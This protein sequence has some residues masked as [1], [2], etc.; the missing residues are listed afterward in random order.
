MYTYI[1]IYMYT[2]MCVCVLR[3]YSVALFVY[4]HFSIYQFIIVCW[5]YTTWSTLWDLEFAYHIGFL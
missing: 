1:Y 4:S 3:S 2:Y 5:S